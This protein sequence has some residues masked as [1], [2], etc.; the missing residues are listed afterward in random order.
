MADQ[1]W[2]ASG[3]LTLKDIHLKYS[4]D[5][6]LVLRGVTMNIQPGD[7]VALVGRTGAGK[8]SLLSV[9]FRLTEPTSGSITIDGIDLSKLGLHDAR[10]ALSIIPQSPWLFSGTIRKNVDPFG[11][12]SDDEIWS[13]LKSCQL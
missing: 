9:L 2:P 10:G 12:R 3:S 5:A 13:A 7:K 11:A 4:K 8:S 6:P 1:Q